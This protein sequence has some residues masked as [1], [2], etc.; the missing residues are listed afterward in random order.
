MLPSDLKTEQFAQYPPLGRQ[1]AIA[2]LAL[3]RALPLALAPLLLQEV[4]TYDW[5]F[6]A[7]RQDID[8]QLAYLGSL[9]AAQLR[10]AMAQFA[11]IQVTPLPAV[12]W[13]SYPKVFSAQLS[14][15]L[16]ATGQ[17]DQFRAASIG[18]VDACRRFRPPALPPLSRLTMVIVGQGVDTPAFPLFRKLRPHGVY[19]SAVEP[20]TALQAIS[21][22]L[23]ARAD[24]HPLPYGHWYVDGGEPAIV[25]PSTVTSMSY[26]GLSNLRIAVVDKMRILG[27][28]SGGPEGLEKALQE[29]DPSQFPDASEGDD[30]VMS[31][32]RLSIFSEGSGTQFYSTTFAEWTAHELLRRA[33]PVTLLVRFAPRQVQRTFDEMIM[34]QNRAVAVDPQGSL[35]DADMGAYYIW[36]NQRR[37]PKSDNGRFLVWFQGH[38]EAV[39]IAL[40]LVPG[41]EDPQ[42]VSLQ[43]L[44]QES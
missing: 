21:A 27:R 25:P 36:L 26:A 40:H 35:L 39:M 16:W 5:K 17:I 24:N 32:F 1:L 12:D 19:Y 22:V 6:P 9:T 3:L 29:L 8:E 28:E 30:P 34:D 15:I 37:L 23:A 33:Q 14:A 43:K 10:A 4:S 42:P 41:T 38:S 31:R 11:A 2:H 18:Y 44:L 7:E 20:S 13:V